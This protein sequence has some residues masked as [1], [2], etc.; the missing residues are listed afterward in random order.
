MALEQTFGEGN[1]CLLLGNNV[2]SPEVGIFLG[3]GISGCTVVGGNSKTNVVDLGTGNV[4]TGVNNMGT[5][6]GPTIRS[7]MRMKK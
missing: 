1:Q 3:E 4:L 2:Q 5:G 7:F 6:V